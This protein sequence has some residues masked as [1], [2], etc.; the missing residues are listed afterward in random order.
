MLGKLL[1]YDFR[2]MWKQFSIVWPAAL[3]IALINRFTLPWQGNTSLL[4][5]QADSLLAQL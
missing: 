1:K 4:G 5:A 2:A 3:A